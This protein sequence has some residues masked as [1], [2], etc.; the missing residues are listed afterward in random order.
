MIKY[1]IL[2]KRLRH[3]FPKCIKNENKLLAMAL[4]TANDITKH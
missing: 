4:E 3:N 1:N 2:S